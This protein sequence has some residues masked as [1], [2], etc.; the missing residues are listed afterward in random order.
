MFRWCPRPECALTRAR[1]DLA[2]PWRVTCTS[3]GGNENTPAE[4]G[5]DDDDDELPWYAHSCSTVAFLFGPLTSD[6]L[7][8]SP[9]WVFLARH[10]VSLLLSVQLNDTF[11]PPGSWSEL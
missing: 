4:R 8:Q 5:E 3:V 1:R 10:P 6:T 11:S 9:C 2:Q 7:I